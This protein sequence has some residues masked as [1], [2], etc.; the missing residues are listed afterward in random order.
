MTPIDEG[1]AV[2]AFD[3]ST[4]TW[5]TLTPAD[6][7]EP[8]P[9]ARSYHC[10]TA[11]PNAVI[12][13]AGCGDAATGRLNDVWSFSLA[14]R[15]WTKLPDAPGA[16]RGGATIAHAAGKL[17]RFGGFNGTTEVGGAID[18]LALD[19]GEWSSL[20]FG[21]QEGLSREA[22]GDLTKGAAAGPGHRSVSGLHSVGDDKLVLLFGEGKPSITG[23]HDAAGNFWDDVW[24]YS[25]ATDTWSEVEAGQ[26]PAA[27]GWFASDV[28]QG[29][30]VLQ[31]GLD[32]SNA[33][34]SDT[35]VLRLS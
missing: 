10:S 3:T 23:G 35:W 20:V 19:A 7:S 14:T 25:P 34:L 28:C 12:V 32:A 18:V 11:T 33:R 2:H 1:G 29:G 16:P 4:K 17:Y 9:A 13:H 22:V 31:G 27:R 15:A 8:Y 21:E 30:V 6:P 26:G 5:Q 24:A